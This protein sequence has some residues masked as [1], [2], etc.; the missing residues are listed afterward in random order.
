MNPL[1]A[2]R[3][4]RFKNPLT[5]RGVAS[6]NLI[7]E[8]EKL[9]KKYYGYIADLEGSSIEVLDLLFVRD[10]IQGI[11]EKIKPDEPIPQLLYEWIYALDFLLWQERLSFL[12]VVGKK[13]LEHTREQQKSPRSHWWWYLDELKVPLAQDALKQKAFFSEAFA[14]N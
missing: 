5:A 9:T 4:I 3:L 10:R 2:I 13:E 12:A 8:L 7:G 6:M 14:Q 1:T 11:L